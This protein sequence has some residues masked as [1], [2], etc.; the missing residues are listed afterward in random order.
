M[1]V[2]NK[3]VAWQRKKATKAHL[4]KNVHQKERGMD[5]WS[6]LLHRAH[7]LLKHWYLPGFSP[8]R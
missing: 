2:G 6:A 8:G 5:R 1:R 4:N 3:V 7:T